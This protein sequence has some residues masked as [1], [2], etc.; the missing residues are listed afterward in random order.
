MPQKVKN[1]KFTDQ[2]RIGVTVISYFYIGTYI[3][4]YGEIHTITYSWPSLNL[5]LIWA[6]YH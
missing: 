4:F 2:N 3:D 1:S 6:S 5:A